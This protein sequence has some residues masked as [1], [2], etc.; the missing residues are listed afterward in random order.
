MKYFDIAANFIKNDE[1]IVSLN[2]NN[3]RVTN[4]DIDIEANKEESYVKNK[5]SLEN[6]F[7]LECQGYHPN[8]P[9]Y[10]TMFSVPQANTESTK[11]L[12]NTDRW[13]S[14]F[15]MQK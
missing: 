12:R 2:Y 15:T 5:F 4:Y 13:A 8:N 6:L 7:D 9:A 1:S 3:C 14:E 11:D 10:D